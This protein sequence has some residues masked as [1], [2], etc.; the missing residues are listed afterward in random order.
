MVYQSAAAGINMKL[1]IPLLCSQLLPK[2][3]SKSFVNHK[4]VLIKTELC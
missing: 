4:P 3:R 2:P 1:M